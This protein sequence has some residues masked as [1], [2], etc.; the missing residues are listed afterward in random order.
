VCTPVARALCSA[1]KSPVHSH[2]SHVTASSEE[3][4]MSRHPPSHF[5]GQRGALSVQLLIHNN[6]LACKCGVH[7]MLLLQ[8][9]L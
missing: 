4:H 5:M 3:Q 9:H 7:P 6:G 1:A 2:V 8:R